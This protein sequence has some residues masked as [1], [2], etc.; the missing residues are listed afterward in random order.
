MTCEGFATWVVVGL[1][2]GSLA[3]IA[4]KD[5]GRGLFWDMTLGLGGSLIGAGYSQFLGA[6]RRQR[7]S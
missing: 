1:L 5:R 7:G 6:H 3:R 2:T 4:A